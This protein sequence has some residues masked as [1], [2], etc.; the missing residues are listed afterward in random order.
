MQ[1]MSVGKCLEKDRIRIRG[2]TPI[3]FLTNGRHTLLTCSMGQNSQ[4]VDA[5]SPFMTLSWSR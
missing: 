1:A 4:G 3:S 5:H 2:D